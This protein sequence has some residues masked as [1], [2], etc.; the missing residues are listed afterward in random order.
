MRAL[1]L[2][3]VHDN[4]QQVASLLDFIY[5]QDFYYLIS[6]DDIAN[7]NIGLIEQ[8]F[9]QRGHK[10]FAIRASFP[11]AWGG[12]SQVLAWIDALRFA[13]KHFQD[14]DYALNLSGACLPIRPLSDLK[15]ILNELK[16]G[17]ADVVIQ[18]V[19]TPPWTKDDNK[20]A[21]FDYDWVSNKNN[22]EL[23]NSS[24]SNR[25]KVVFQQEAEKY[26]WS[27]LDINPIMKWYLRMGLHCQD[28][29]GAKT[30]GIRHLFP[31][32]V[33]TRSR[34]LSEIEFRTGRVWF[35]MGRSFVVRMLLDPIFEKIVDGFDNSLCADEQVFSSYVATLARNGSINPVNW[36]LHY[37]S[38]DPIDVEDQI[39]DKLLGSGA[40][41]VRKVNYQN[42]PGLLSD[43]KNIMTKK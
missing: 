10:N 43:I 2:L 33:K 16:D 5:D 38:G 14:W 25:V 41:F 7:F 32:E 22:N 4:A 34:F 18:H 3:Q 30:L 29:Y 42:C 1:F 13:T 15:K 36:N 27:N 24:F 11:V 28:F 21:F 8:I 35:V 12:F 26:F 39:A 37:K 23:I 17:K 40:Y 6:V 20:Q 31:H 9:T 19:G